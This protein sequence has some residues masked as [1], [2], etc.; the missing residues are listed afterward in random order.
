MA[1]RLRNLLP[2]VCV[3]AAVGLWACGGGSGGS[4]SSSPTAPSANPEAQPALP[5][6]G[7]IGG[8]GT[9]ATTDT[10][11]IVRG[12]ECSTANT[13]VV[14]LNL[15]DRDGQQS[16]QCSGTIISRRAVLTAAHCLSG[17]TAS[18]RVFQGTGD[19]VMSASIHGHPTYREDDSQALDVGIVVTSQDLDHPVVPLLLSRDARVGEQAV[20]AGWGKDELGNGT[21]LRA[22]AT[23]IAA[24][25]SNFLQ[26]DISAT[27]SGVCSG[28]S[29]GPILLSEGGVW[30]IAGV[31]SSASTGGSCAIGSNYFTSVRNA[32]V[33]S[34]VL[35]LV[36]DVTER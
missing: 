25:Y 19:Q 12:T 11:A 9:A 18:V 31:T 21:I 22:A 35:G 27:G 6:C 34:F 5:A 28:D 16:G 29:G 13:P 3:A 32:S 30:S 14:L 1:R 23:L 36:P 15:R 2:G 20:I 26:T 10:Y 4:S 8:F 33:R 17:E 24:V 7:A